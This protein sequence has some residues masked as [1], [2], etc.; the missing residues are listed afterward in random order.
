MSSKNIRLNGMSLYNLFLRNTPLWSVFI[1]TVGVVFISVLIGHRLGKHF[2]LQSEHKTATFTSSV[3]AAS[4]GLLAF[5]LAFTFGLATARFDMR[6]QILLD[7]VNAIGTTYLRANLLD[8][9]ASIEIKKLLLEYVD[10]RADLLS[11]KKYQNS[12]KNIQDFI[13][14]SL[15][16]QKKLWSSASA[17]SKQDRQSIMT[18]LFIMSLNELIDLHTNRVVVALQYH[19]PGP[20]WGALYLISILSFGLVGYEIGASGRGGIY[21]S[22]ILA[23]TFST[24]IY[25]IADLDRPMQG[26]INVNQEP[27]REL[28]QALH[29]DLP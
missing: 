17:V 2:Y 20:I 21:V 9:P 16:I 27:M 10:L 4:L 22:I 19:I 6:K 29:D 5:M 15:S 13:A 24:V 7:E 1:F 11:K 8:A 26:N 23:I 3:V 14:S 25:L 28:Q 18:G 12:P